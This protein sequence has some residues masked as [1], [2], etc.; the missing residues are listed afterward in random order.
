MNDTIMQISLDAIRPREG[1]RRA[2]GF[3][4]ARLH[5]LA[6]SIKAIGVQ[7]PAVVRPAP[8]HHAVATQYELVA[9][10]RRWRAAK[11]AGLETLPCVVRELTDVQALEIA[12][13]ENLQRED[14]HPLDEADGYRQLV[15]RASYTVEQVAGKVGKSASYVYQR[16]KLLDLVDEAR[17]LLLDGKLSA[18]AAILVAR[19]PEAQQRQLLKSRMFKGED[20]PSVRELDEVIHCDY[21]LDLSGAAFRKDDE[22]LSPKAG[23]CTTCPKRTGFQPL[24]FADLCKN[25]KKRD[26]CTDPPCFNGKLDA[27]LARKREELQGKDV[28]KVAGQGF[29]GAIREKD[30]LSPWDI[31]PA[32]KGDPDA[33]LALVVAGPDRG[34]TRYVKPRGRPGASHATP[35]E[36]AR[37][38]RELLEWQ[39]EREVPKRLIK[40]IG[41]AELPRIAQAQIPEDM[42]QVIFEGSVA[43][44]DYSFND[45]CKLNGWS[46]PETEEAPAVADLH[47]SPQQ[48]LLALYQMALLTLEQNT[49]GAERGKRLLQLAKQHDIDVKALRAEIR[50]ELKAAERAKDAAK[51]AKP[52]VQ[53]ELLEGDDVPEENEE[54]AE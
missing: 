19:M 40:A 51:K 11:I 47:L 33:K 35:A 36:K 41:E 43:V 20:G 52:A 28:V 31:E 10:E 22:T 9:G 21:L 26:Y 7:Q 30:V 15:D 12:T 14:V 49:F 32:K 16:L 46:D 17:Q 42:L 5:D 2:G 3:D 13:V 48:M 53:D 8:G 29:Y 50:A 23:P 37:Q 44:D 34:K 25:G 45:I 18:G 1:N 6:E 54:S 24:L 39:I 27:Y 38:K 4:E